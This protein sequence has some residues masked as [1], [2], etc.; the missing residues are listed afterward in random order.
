MKNIFVA[1]FAFLFSTNILSADLH[2]AFSQKD[3][4]LC[5]ALATTFDGI[6]AELLETCIYDA[7]RIRNTHQCPQNVD[8]VSC[9][10]TSC[11]AKP[12]VENLTEEMLVCLTKHLSGEDQKLMQA[13]AV[14]INELAQSLEGKS[15]PVEKKSQWL[16]EYK[17]QLENEI[18]DAIMDAFEDID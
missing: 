13:V 15:N 1:I 4:E 2:Y 11:N 14:F 17:E 5:T 18:N 10:Q 3:T 8:T 9:L 6:D 7:Q 16:K 12:P